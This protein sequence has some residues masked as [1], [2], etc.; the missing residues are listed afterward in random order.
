MRGECAGTTATLRKSDSVPDRWHEG[1]EAQRKR[2]KSVVTELSSSTLQGQE[3]AGGACAETACCLV[4][5]NEVTRENSFSP[6][7]VVPGRDINIES[8]LLQLEII[9]A[10]MDQLGLGGGEGRRGNTV[11]TAG[12]RRWNRRN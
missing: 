10:R 4:R 1:E 8:A 12:T 11:V 9:S 6:A 5:E 2:M 3:G 7:A